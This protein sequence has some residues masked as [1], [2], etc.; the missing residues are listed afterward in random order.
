MHVHTGPQSSSVT[1]S[2]CP[3][4][5]GLTPHLKVCSE[6]PP[7]RDMGTVRIPGGVL[8]SP[9]AEAGQPGGMWE[10]VDPRR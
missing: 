7:N 6:E 4:G 1:G 9:E 10:E 2:S 3:Q 8:P 5:C